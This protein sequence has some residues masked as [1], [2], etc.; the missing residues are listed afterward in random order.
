[1]GIGQHCLQANGGQGK[2]VVRVQSK[3]EGGEQ[4]GRRC[5]SWPEAE[6][7][8]RRGSDV[9]GQK[10]DVPAQAKS[11][12]PSRLVVLLRPSWIGGCLLALARAVFF[13]QSINSNADFLLKHPHRH[14]QE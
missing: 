1:M 11:K 14:I 8:R 4:G 7:L 2:L 10:A 13:T 6:G 5:E 3:P 12:S 9:H